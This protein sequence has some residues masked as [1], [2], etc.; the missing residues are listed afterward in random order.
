MNT[1]ISPLERSLGLQISVPT[2]T[3]RDKR[4]LHSRRNKKIYRKLGSKAPSIS[5]ADTRNRD[6]I[7]STASWSISRGVDVNMARIVI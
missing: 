1:L 6:P 4:A 7:F 5:G 2:H 3:A